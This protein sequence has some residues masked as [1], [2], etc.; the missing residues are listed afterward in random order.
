M[1]TIARYMNMRNVHGMFIHTYISHRTLEL[2]T[3]KTLDYFFVQVRNLLLPLSLK[4][5]QHKEKRAK[6]RRT[7]SVPPRK[8]KE[9]QSFYSGFIICP[10]PPPHNTCGTSH[11][12]LRKQAKV[13]RL[14]FKI[15]QNPPHASGV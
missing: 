1:C 12:G 6:T 11:K 9:A 3:R 14:F 13:N 7:N 4:V 8:K 15:S 10:P 2:E 5:L